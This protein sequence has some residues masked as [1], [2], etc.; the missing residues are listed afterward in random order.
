MANYQTCPSFG[1][2][3]CATCADLY[4]KGGQ[5]GPPAP[6]PGADIS[7]NVPGAEGPMA[8]RSRWWLWLAIG[9]GLG[10]LAND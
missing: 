1:D 3:S 6:V 8:C 7:I 2:V 9:V 4:P 10:Y 5:P